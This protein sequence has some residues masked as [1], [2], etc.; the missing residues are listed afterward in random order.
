MLFFIVLWGVLLFVL[1]LR[2]SR[3]KREIAELRN[4]IQPR[5]SVPE[6]QPQPAAAPIAQPIAP[7]VVAAP[8]PP[9]QPPPSAAP[10]PAPQP[11]GPTF[12]ER[13]RK[14]L[15][16]EQMLGSN[17][18]SKIGVA[19]LV[20]GI[21]FFLAWQ[22]R[23]LGPGGKITVGTLVA[24]ALLGSGIWAERIDRYRILGRAALAGGWSLLFFV[25]YAAHHIPA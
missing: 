5:V 23:E 20:L 8:P 15:D 9:P 10:P 3:L 19:I 7:V 17:W 21:A 2:T 18:L 4:A 6:P 22:L 12:G 1:W 11:A 13:V 14:L 16:V 25:A 24:A